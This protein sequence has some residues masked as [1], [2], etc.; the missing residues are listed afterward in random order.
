MKVYVILESYMV[1]VITKGLKERH[2]LIKFRYFLVQLVLETMNLA[3]FFF[4]RYDLEHF[5]VTV[6]ELVVP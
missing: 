4:C 5:L 3:L 6:V 1:D 2:Y